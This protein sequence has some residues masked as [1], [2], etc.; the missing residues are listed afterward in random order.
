MSSPLLQSPL[1]LKC[2][3]PT[4]THSF[5]DSTVMATTMAFG[6]FFAYVITFFI[7]SAS[8]IFLIFSSYFLVLGFYF[9]SFQAFPSD[10]ILMVFAAY[11]IK[12]MV[13]LTPYLLHIKQIMLIQCILVVYCFYIQLYNYLQW[14]AM[15]A[16]FIL[17]TVIGQ[18]D[19]S[20]IGLCHVHCVGHYASD[21]Y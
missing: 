16:L 2:S 1:T 11:E 9:I 4:S 21:V 5:E 8:V 13:D 6:A 7:A 17:C 10:T 3:S 19:L 15:G 20:V 12:H 18:F 14:P